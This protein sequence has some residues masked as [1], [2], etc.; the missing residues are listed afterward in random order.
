MKAVSVSVR[1]WLQFQSKKDFVSSEKILKT[2]KKL[3]S[4]LKVL[5]DQ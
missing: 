5:A 2:S 4:F 3:F 1:I